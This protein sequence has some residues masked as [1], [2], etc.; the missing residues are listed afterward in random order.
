M[1]LWAEEM[2][3]LKPLFVK[4]HNADPVKRQ[5]ILIKASLE[6]ASK[7]IVPR[8]RAEMAASELQAE[9]KDLL[10]PIE[11]KLL[12]IKDQPDQG[13]AEDEISALLLD[14]SKIRAQ[15]KALALELAAHHYRGLPDRICAE[16][17]ATSTRFNV[18]A[19]ALQRL[20]KPAPA[21]KEVQAPQK[22]MMEEGPRALKVAKYLTVVFSGDGHKARRDFAQWR[23]E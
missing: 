9:A 12:N 7:K 13:T 17:Q 20:Q 21:P 3:L 10:A 19:M 6:K 16:V 11:E 5:A 8:F 1:E 14:A 18:A 15:V 23:S 22:I 2:A 4:K